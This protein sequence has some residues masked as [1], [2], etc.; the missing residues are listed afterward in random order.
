KKGLIDKA[1]G[2]VHLEKDVVITSD[3]GAQVTTDTLNWNRNK[4]VVSTE[5][6]VEITDDALKITGKG[7]TAQPDLKTASIHENV[8]AD[9]TANPKQGASQN[10]SITSDGPMEMDQLK[11]VVIFNENVVATEIL[12]GRQLKA[13]KMEVYFDQQAKGIKKLVCIGNVSVKQGENISYSDRLT[14][15]AVTQK[16]TLT[17]KPKLV[18]DLNSE[19]GSGKNIFKGLGV[20]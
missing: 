1:S 11:Q 20:N 16:M 12:T 19:G 8:K 5:D 6:A 3:Q 10:I 7:M 14:Y 17:G 4:N 18:F 15:D 2:D 9:V 13:D